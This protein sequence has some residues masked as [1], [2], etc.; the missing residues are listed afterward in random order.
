MASD[1]QFGTYSNPTDPHSF[2]I[3]NRSGIWQACLIGCQL[4]R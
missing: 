2:Q 1:P 3:E 4:C